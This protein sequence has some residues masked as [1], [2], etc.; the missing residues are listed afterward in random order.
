MVSTL[1]TSSSSPQYIYQANAADTI[2]G[3]TIVFD[4]GVAVANVVKKIQLSMVFI[5]LKTFT[6]ATY[7]QNIPESFIVAVGGNGYT[8]LAPAPGVL[9]ASTLV[10]A[11][12]AATST[13]LDLQ[14]YNGGTHTNM[15][16]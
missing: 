5:G 6:A 15:G 11:Y 13:V 9:A 10:D 14:T 16:H 2:V 3:P 8:D 12:I 4:T 7:P 1:Q